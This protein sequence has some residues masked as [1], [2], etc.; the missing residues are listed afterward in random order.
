MKRNLTAII[1]VSGDFSDFENNLTVR[2][3]LFKNYYSEYVEYVLVDY[4][5]DPNNCQ[6]FKDFCQTNA[7]EYVQCKNCS[8]LNSS[9]AINE[10]IRYAKSEFLILEDIDL[11]HPANFYKEIHKKLLE[12]W[13]ARGFNFYTIPVAYLNQSESNKITLEPNILSDEKYTTQLHDA[14]ELGISNKFEHFV[15][16]SSLIVLKKKT[17]EYVGLF[18]ESFTGWGGEDRDFIF[19][20]I[21]SNNRIKLNPDFGY[22]STESGSRISK[23]VGW[24]AIW[25]LHGDFSYN[26]GFLSYH[27]YHSPREWKKGDV[28]GLA[29][30]TIQYAM[31]KA[32]RIGTH[33]FNYLSPSLTTESNYFIYGR[34]PH[35]HNAD[36]FEACGGFNIL[37]ETW[38]IETIKKQLNKDSKIIFW[39]PYGSTARLHVFKNLKK[40]GYKVFVAERGALPH[41]IVF[42][43]DDLVIFS[44]RYE[45]NYWDKDISIEDENRTV[46]Y[47]ESLK[48]TGETLEKQ[49]NAGKDFLIFSINKRKFTKII[50]VC[51]QLSI[52]TVTNQKVDGYISYATYLDEIKNLAE[53]LPKEYC[54]L[55]KNHPLSA[56]KIQIPG[57]F[58]VDQF[59]INDLL[60]VSDC[61]LTYNSGT[62]IIARSFGKPVFTFGPN[63]YASDDFTYSVESHKQ[64][65]EILKKPLKIIQKNKIIRYFSYLINEYYSFA[66]FNELTSRNVTGARLV[67]PKQI[68]YTK[69]RLPGLVDKNFSNQYI[70]FDGG[71][72]FKRF[73]WMDHQA[74]KNTTP[75]ISSSAKKTSPVSKTLNEKQDAKNR[76]LMKL[77]KN[78]YGY[79]NDSKYPIRWM[80]HFFSKKQ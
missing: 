78:P 14:V 28:N 60:D 62:G 27:L 7:W 43:P 31:Q 40:S 25:T 56:E 37:E 2:A 54:L 75:K 71:N 74:T 57:A 26:L 61:V 16:Q 38:S 65:L 45:K 47:L 76:L 80:R 46:R 15:P 33:Y 10:G 69:I 48:Q 32:K 63:S 18:D 50:L 53:N 51:L 17:A 55:L 9:R 6:K 8:S 36:L 20:L 59:H 5:E 49:G 67:Y 66:N 73:F 12:N 3:N 11:I 52:D 13:N 21:T 41:S 1:R 42:D 34:N 68:S 30:Q 39:N 44:N 29:R 4:S 22:T 72:L 24:K 19:R 35:I 64:V 23:Y 79:F 77:I 70:S 58:D